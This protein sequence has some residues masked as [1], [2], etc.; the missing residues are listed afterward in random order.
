MSVLFFGNDMGIS[1]AE[2]RRRTLMCGTG[3]QA[4][5][6]LLSL[7]RAWRWE[8]RDNERLIVEVRLEDCRVIG[9]SL[10]LGARIITASVGNDA[11][12]DPTD[13]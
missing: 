11:A 13:G 5:W 2:E 12:A 8:E 10:R 9:N 7:Q 4:T 3:Y 1:G 6:T